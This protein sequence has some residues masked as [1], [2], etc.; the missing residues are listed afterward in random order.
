MIYNIVIFDDDKTQCDIIEKMINENVPDL[1][2]NIVTISDR[3]ELDNYMIMENRVDIL[4]TDI[5]IDKDDETG[6]DIVKKL[7]AISPGTQIIYITG[8]VEYCEEV[9]ETNHISFIRKPVNNERLK[10]AI[11]K[12]VKNIS[13]QDSR[14]YTIINRHSV[15]NLKLQDIMYIESI[16][17][18]LVYNCV[19][20]NAVET[21]GKLSEIEQQ[22]GTGFVRCHK[23]FLVNIEYIKELTDTDIE[24]ADGRKVAVSRSYY[25][26]TRRMLLNYRQ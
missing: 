3:K 2:K 25:N 16:K 7:H 18:K 9:Y 13:E 22:L 6:I 5:C 11:D 26:D 17:R 19:D 21:Y 1:T 4:I 12:A 15:I 24:L 8:Y 23:R 14:I 10:A 20:G